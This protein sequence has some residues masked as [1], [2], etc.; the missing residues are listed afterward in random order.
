MTSKKCHLNKSRSGKP[1]SPTAAEVQPLQLA[2]PAASSAPPTPSP[3]STSTSNTV[4]GLPASVQLPTVPTPPSLLPAATLNPFLMSPMALTTSMNQL[5]NNGGFNQQEVLKNMQT[6]LQ[7]FASLTTPAVKQ[8]KRPN[9]ADTLANVFEEQDLSNLRNLLETVN[10]NVTRS[11]LEDNL[12]KW[13]Q[14]LIWEQL[15][16]AKPI[17][18]DPLHTSEDQSMDDDLSDEDELGAERKSRSRTL[19]SDDQVAVLKEVYAVNPKPKR[20]EL[21]QLADQLGHTFKVVKVWFQNTRAR[22]RKDGG[23]KRLETMAFTSVPSSLKSLNPLPTHMVFSK[24]PTPPASSADINPQSPGLAPNSPT[25]MQGKPSGSF[26][27]L[28]LSTKRSSSCDTPPPL[29]I[30]SD[31]EDSEDDEDDKMDVDNAKSQFEKMIQDKLVSLSPSTVAILPKEPC[32]PTKVMSKVKTEP[33]PNVTNGAAPVAQNGVY[34]CDQ[35]DK[36][37]TKKSSITRHKYEH[38][39]TEQLLI[40]S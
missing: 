27:P 17:P 7:D 36:T 2:S 8:L 34:K 26:T 40:Q 10:A 9:I 11:L 21:M 13:S 6:M 16:Q 18:P 24:F 15:A 35:C 28:D 12:K 4:N 31:A 39:G 23:N 19:I 38:S 1:P 25:P 3:T 37:F 5:L 33:S 20:E 29:V 22:D 14:S 32:P 30:N